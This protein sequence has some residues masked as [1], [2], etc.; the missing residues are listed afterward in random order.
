M[1]KA[2]SSKIK[3][4]SLVLILSLVITSAVAFLILVQNIITI[5]NT[6]KSISSDYIRQCENITRLYGEKIEQKL[7]EL[8]SALG[9]YTN[10][11]SVQTKN[12]RLIIESLKRNRISRNRNFEY[13]AYVD[14]EGNFTSDEDATTNVMDREYFHAIMKEG[15]DFTVD[16]PVISKSSGKYVVHICR[17][18]KVNGKTIGFFSGIV[19]VD[20]FNEILRDAK[21]GE[22]G[23]SIMIARDGTYMASSMDSE[24]AKKV[25]EINSSRDF[26]TELSD[27]K[28]GLA[29]SMWLENSIGKFLSTHY[30][31]DGAPW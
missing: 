13:V 20:S 27:L 15:K 8:N 23:Y 26:R 25:I 10:D 9:I 29:Q 16:I 18:A 1:E 24:S 5:R 7:D 22:S 4:R 6:Q 12:T 28:P 19:L 11:E 3:Q 17:A 31:V 21:I 30:I 2:A 14:A